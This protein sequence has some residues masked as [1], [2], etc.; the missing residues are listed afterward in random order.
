MEF[1]RSYDGTVALGW[2]CAV[3]FVAATREASH[4]D[5]AFMVQL[6]YGVMVAAVVI[7]ALMLYLGWKMKRRAEDMVR[8]SDLNPADGHPGAGEIELAVAGR[9][10]SPTSHPDGTG[11]Q[12]QRL[13]PRCPKAVDRIAACPSYAHGSVRHEEPGD[14][15]VLNPT[16][17]RNRLLC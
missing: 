11:A 10:H 1:W 7:L 5:E 17:G 2:F 14:R 13:G 8:T 15:E 3:A 9:C 6:A 4:S 16:G 12:S